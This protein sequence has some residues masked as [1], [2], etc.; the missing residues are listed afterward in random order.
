MTLLKTNM[1]GWLED[2]ARRLRPALALFLFAPVAIGLSQSLPHTYYFW[3]LGFLFPFTVYD[4][5]L[6]ILGL[7]VIAAGFASE[8]QV[9]IVASVFL[10]ALVSTLFDFIGMWQVFLAHGWDDQVY[11]VTPLAVGLTGASLWLPARARFP[12]AIL[13]AVLL[14]FDIALFIGLNEFSNNIN[15]FSAGCI[16][17]VGWILIAPAFLLRCFRRPWLTIAG[18]IL[19]SWLVAIELLI[20]AFAVVPIHPAAGG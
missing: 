17:A 6:A 11:L 9:A 16:I 12:A 3:E 7:G 18:R 19:G 5:A 10:V 20:F 2:G 13:L 15:P 14:A 1:G 4:I 8:R